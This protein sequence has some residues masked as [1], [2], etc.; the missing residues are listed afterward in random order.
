MKKEHLKENRPRATRVNFRIHM[1][2][3]FTNGGPPFQIYLDDFTRVSHLDVLTTKGEAFGKWV[4]LKKH[5]ENRHFECKVAFL[6]TDNDT[7]YTSKEFTQHCREE[8]VEHEYSPHFR[9]DLNGSIERAVQT[10]GVTFRVLMF[11]G[12]APDSDIPDALLHAN[13]IRNNSPTKANSGWT[14]KE[15]ELGMKLE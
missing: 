11:H 2:L 13:V 8:G 1:D 6:R 12:N 14:P 9:H 5:L 4:E 15:R 10:I 3:A 7:V